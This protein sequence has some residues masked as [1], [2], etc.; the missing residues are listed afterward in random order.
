MRQLSLA[1]LFG[2]LVAL[3]APSVRVAAAELPAEAA[4]IR[5]PDVKPLAL[6]TGRPLPPGP[7]TENSGIVRSRLWPDVFWM[8]NDSG[9]EPRIYP[10]R[11][12]GSTFAQ[13]RDNDAAPGI[14]IGGA[15]NVDWEDIAVDD[16]GHV[17]IADVGNNGNNRRDL[18][19]YYLAEPAPTAER[20]TFLR[21][22]FVRYEDQ[23]SF[24][25]PADDFNY[26]AEAVFT[27]GAQVFVL[28]KHRS[29]TAT[30]LYR[31]DP[32]EPLPPGGEAATLRLLDR[33]ELGG[34]ATAADASTDGKRLIV[35][36]Y[37]AFWLF[38][39]ADPRFPLRGAV[40][41]LP[42]AGPE[43]IEAV[44]FADDSTIL[45]ADEVS[46]RLFEISLDRFIPVRG[47]LAGASTAA[48]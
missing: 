29:D 38:E 41:W 8:H 24:P 6:E 19:L 16:R 2:A 31:Y 32:E 3:V 25:A 14:E 23:P 47:A 21:R 15:I 22:V 36:A 39:I 37:N 20:T 17:I 43:Q 48:P 18:A 9:D 11:R 5:L 4:S 44:C 35:A 45:A 27:L 7:A 46:A 34:Q 42:F 40:S 12:D 26:D 28:T 1:V 10:V 13:E 30:K 33:F